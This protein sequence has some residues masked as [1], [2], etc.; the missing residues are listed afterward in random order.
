ME[1][2]NFKNKEGKNI[3][4]YKWGENLN[5]PKGIIQLAHGMSE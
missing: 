5:N 4:Y 2:C 3:T 1:I